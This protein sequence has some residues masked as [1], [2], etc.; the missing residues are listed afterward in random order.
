MGTLMADAISSVSGSS[1]A[2]STRVVSRASPE[3]R[4]QQAPQQRKVPAA[5]DARPAPAQ[6]TRQIAQADQ[7]RQA[8]KVAEQSFLTRQDLAAKA[9]AQPRE[10]APRSVGS[11]I[12][13][14][15]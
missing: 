6:Q 14:T 12:N 4:I 15:A 3:Q 8:D 13:T 9:A 2:A 5:A 10:A 11:T 1:S 7:A